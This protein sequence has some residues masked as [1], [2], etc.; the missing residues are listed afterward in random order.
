MTGMPYFFTD[1]TAGDTLSDSSN[2]RS[3]I[4]IKTFKLLLRRKRF[5]ATPL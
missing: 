4:I 1:K 3:V 5:V 2:E